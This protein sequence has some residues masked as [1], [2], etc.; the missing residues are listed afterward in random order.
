LIKQK[1]KRTKKLLGIW[2]APPRPSGTPPKRE[3]NE[4]PKRSF[5]KLRM[6]KSKNENQ[7][8][9]ARQNGVKACG[10]KHRSVLSYSPFNNF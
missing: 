9:P 4:Q 1:G 2:L 5:D 8:S 10:Q 7:K 6:T 3:G